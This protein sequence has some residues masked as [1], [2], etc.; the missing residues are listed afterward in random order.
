MKMKHTEPN[1]SWGKPRN[2]GCSSR[3]STSKHNELRG[4]TALTPQSCLQ[5]HL[6]GDELTVTAENN[7]AREI[8]K[9]GA[10]LSHTRLKRELLPFPTLHH[11]V[12]S[13]SKHPALLLTSTYCGL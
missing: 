8:T 11:Y 10:V 7:L 2:Q 3:Q 5:L 13:F 12:V 9:R 6:K 1:V 4:R